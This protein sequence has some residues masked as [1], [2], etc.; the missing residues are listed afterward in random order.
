MELSCIDEFLEMYVPGAKQITRKFKILK[1]GAIIIHD[2]FF[3]KTGKIWRA[4]SRDAELT[5]ESSFYYDNK[6]ENIIAIA[7]A[8]SDTRQL[9]SSGE[10]QY[11][12]EGRISRERVY[13][14]SWFRSEIVRASERRLIER[15]E[16]RDDLSKYIQFTEPDS[17][18]E[19][20]LPANIFTYPR[21]IT[22]KYEDD[23][24]TKVI[25]EGYENLKLITK[26]EMKAGKCV[27]EF[28]SRFNNEFMY[29]SLFEY[30]S[31]G[32]I[33]KE[34]SL[35]DDGSELGCTVFK[36]GTFGQ[37]LSE[38]IR[39]GTQNIFWEHNHTFN[40]FGHI[41]NTV[42]FLDGELHSITDFTIDYYDGTQVMLSL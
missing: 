14:Q 38:N 3:L 18:V 20:Q 36:Y 1:T 29:C 28:S 26:F 7:S 17:N 35:D 40:D 15:R 24:H 9:I 10:Y 30:D 33:S 4:L 41:I 16:L 22:Y 2:L 27:K 42:S 13:E 23:L 25:D 11:D 6:F 8:S 31:N 5:E 19:D 32:R 39:I 21:L 37:L 12:S 34:I